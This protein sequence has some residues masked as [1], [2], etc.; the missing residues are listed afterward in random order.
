MQCIQGIVATV[1]LC[2]IVTGVRADG[3]SFGPPHGMLKV[4]VIDNKIVGN[5][6]QLSFEDRVTFDADGHSILYH[7]EGEGQK[8][9]EEETLLGGIADRTVK[10]INP[11]TGAWIDIGAATPSSTVI[12]ADDPGFISSGGPFDSFP[13][14]YLLRATFSGALRYFTEDSVAWTRPVSGEQLRVFDMTL[15]DDPFE[16]DKIETGGTGRVPAGFLEAI[17]DAGSDDLDRPI[18]LQIRPDSSQIHAHLGYELSIPDGDDDPT[19]NPLAPAK[20]AYM[21]EL[22]LSAINI[23]S[24]FDPPDSEDPVIEDSDPIFFIF[25]NQLSTVLGD[26]SDPFSSDF[27][28]AISAAM[29]LPEPSTAVMM[30]GLSMMVMSR[31]R[32]KGIPG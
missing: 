9:N 22:R 27:G 23:G 13:A 16:D 14:E 26:P 11:T 29:E 15:R 21:I 3:P 32:R 20:A 18:N 5:S 12:F 19:N 28:R 6:G 1:A 7:A 25:N 2:L 10:A 24:A 31:R 30:I 17:Y 8:T 4:E